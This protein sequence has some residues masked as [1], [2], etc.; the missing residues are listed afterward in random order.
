MVSGSLDVIRA[1]NFA[2]FERMPLNSI[3][4][5]DMNCFSDKFSVVKNKKTVG[6]VELTMRQ[7]MKLE[8]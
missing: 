1:G 5:S 4:F 3:H 8:T 7:V 6:Q 2:D